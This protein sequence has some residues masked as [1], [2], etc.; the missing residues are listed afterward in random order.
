MSTSVLGSYKVTI[1]TGRV[2][3]TFRVSSQDT[4]DDTIDLYEWRNGEWVFM[5]GVTVAPMPRLH[6]AEIVALLREGKHDEIE[7]HRHPEPVTAVVDYVDRMLKGMGWRRGSEMHTFPL[8]GPMRPGSAPNRYAELNVR[9]GWRERRY[10]AAVRRE[11][12]ARRD[13]RKHC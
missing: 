8:E 1:E 2:L 12:K 13:S 4:L 5:R 11:I 10:Q 6:E 7:S 3:V 9:R